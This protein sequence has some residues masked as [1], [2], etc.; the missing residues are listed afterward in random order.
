MRKE[1]ITSRHPAAQRPH[2]VNPFSDKLHPLFKTQIQTLTQRDYEH[3]SASVSGRFYVT[4]RMATSG[5]L[6]GSSGM[7]PPPASDTVGSTYGSCGSEGL[8]ASSGGLQS[9][10]QG[11]GMLR[12][13][14]SVAPLRLRPL[15]FSI[16]SNRAFRARLQPF[17][18]GVASSFRM[19]LFF[20]WCTCMFRHCGCTTFG[21]TSNYHSIFS[22]LRV[23]S[24][25][26]RVGAAL[27]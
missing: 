7:E 23:L 9:G 19:H 2:V 18:Q 26:P 11:I 21:A 16:A 15:C 3:L 14:A 8:L 17:R 27:A 12:P 10:G 1:S 20:S 13:L 6:S 24:W 5:I 22:W 4:L 25:I